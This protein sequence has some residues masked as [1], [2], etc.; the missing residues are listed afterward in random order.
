MLRI[1]K[2]VMSLKRSDLFKKYYKSDKHDYEIAETL[3]ADGDLDKIK[4]KAAI[5]GAEPWTEQMRKQIE[6]K[7]HINAFDIYGLSE[8]MGPGV[9][10]DC[11]YHKG[12]HV[13][14][15]CRL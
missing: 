15:F 14:F 7:L 5:C 12:L 10:C 13:Q 1:R 9:A 3:E 6:E 2:K 4:L 11:I 8:V